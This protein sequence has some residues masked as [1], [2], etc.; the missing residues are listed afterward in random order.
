MVRTLAATVLAV[1]VVAPLPRRTDPLTGMTFVRVPAGRFVMG[2][3]ATETQR[4]AQE[5]SHRV[6]LS[7]SFY[8]GV[9]EVTQRQWTRIMGSNPSQ[10]GD[11]A[12]CPVERITYV[13]VQG[14]IAR[15]NARSAWPGYRLPTEAEWEYACRAGARE[16]FGAAATITRA[17]ANFDGSRTTPFGRFAANPFGLFDMSGNVWEWTSDAHC[18]Y[19]AAEVTDPR[20]ACAST[21]KVIRGG[22]WRFGADSAR[23]ALRYTHRPA[24]RGFSLGVRLAHDA[25]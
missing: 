22:S 19:P 15:L 24:D 3:P 9:Y 17:D 21:L 20:G 6:T 25:E 23:C 12:E 11:C 7:R 4:E 10:F 8:I 13:D 18:P 14:F 1:T 5:R 2:S 16:A